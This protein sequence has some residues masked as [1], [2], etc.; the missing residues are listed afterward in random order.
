MRLIAIREMGM[1]RPVTGNL[2]SM[3][4]EEVEMVLERAANEPGFAALLGADPDRMTDFDLEPQEI[5]ALLDQDVDA[6]VDMGVD[7]ELAESAS[8]IGRL[9]G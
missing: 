8:L 5:A 3:S 9:T 1:D 6:L 7:P 4:V 2:H